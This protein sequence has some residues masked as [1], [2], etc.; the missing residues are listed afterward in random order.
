MITVIIHVHRIFS[1]DALSCWIP[2]E[3]IPATT[4]IG[5]WNEP[6]TGH[7]VVGCSAGEAHLL[8]KD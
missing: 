6:F 2:I 5:A 3:L 1:T 4:I 8:N 7:I